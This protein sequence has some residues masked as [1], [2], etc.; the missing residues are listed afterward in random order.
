MLMECEQPAACVARAATQSQVEHAQPPGVG[1][2]HRRTALAEGRLKLLLVLADALHLGRVQR[3][4]LF[5]VVELLGAD[6]FGSLQPHLQLA[7]HGWPSWFA[8]GPVSGGDGLALCVELALHFAPH[9][10]QESA[11]ALD[12]S[13]EALELPGV[14]VAAGLAQFLALIDEGQLEHDAS[15]LG[16]TDHLVAVD[17]H[18]TFSLQHCTSSLSLRLKAFFRYSKLAMSRIDR[19][20]R[21]TLLTPPPNSGACSPTTAS[22][23]RTI[24][25]LEHRRN[26]LLD[27]TPRQP[28]GQH[29]QPMPQIDH[30][31]Q[32]GAKKSSMA[33]GCRLQRT[34]R[35]CPHRTQFRGFPSSAITQN[36]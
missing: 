29:R 25:V 32:A 6:V 27:S 10:A 16:C 17:H 22:L 24:L 26:H 9:H 15:A 35:S 13:D 30:H 19:R 36:R 8:F 2:Q 1:A 34:P 11:P 31:V 20:S 18:T 14:G 33:I 23:G 5:L 7:Q 12:G 4:Q 3:V 28:S 21:P